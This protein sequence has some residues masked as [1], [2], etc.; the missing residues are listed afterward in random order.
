MILNSDN[1]KSRDAVEYCYKRRRT[2]LNPIIDW[3]DSDVWEF[4]HEYNVPYCSL[5]DKGRKRI[6][7]IGC[8]MSNKMKEELEAYP[9]YKK[10][11]ISAFERMLQDKDL[12]KTKSWKDGESVYE[13]WVNG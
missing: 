3:D 6:G 11:Y 4:I 7:C 13:W 12:T 5:Y 8:P 2:I 9:K 10:A 1:D